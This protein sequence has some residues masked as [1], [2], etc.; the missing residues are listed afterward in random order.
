MEILAFQSQKLRF[1]ILTTP[2]AIQMT[3]DKT[4][5]AAVDGMI[6]FAVLLQCLP[7]PE[8]ESREADPAKIYATTFENDVAG[9]ADNTVAT[10]ATT[11]ACATFEL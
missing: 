6:R 5:Q 10:N 7:G 2:K 8:G 3:G 4:E 1:E 9:S 11:V